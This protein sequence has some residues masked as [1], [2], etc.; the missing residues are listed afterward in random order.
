MCRTKEGLPSTVRSIYY[1][2]SEMMAPTGF[3]VR[4]RLTLHSL[5]NRST[6]EFSFG[7]KIISLDIFVACCFGTFYLLLFR[8]VSC[9][10]GYSVSQSPAWRKKLRLAS[11]VL[12]RNGA[13]TVEYSR[14]W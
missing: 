10:S 9:A 8:A 4:K 2:G 12:G 13:R 7:P 1:D 3:L 5:F 6:V 14:T 11:C